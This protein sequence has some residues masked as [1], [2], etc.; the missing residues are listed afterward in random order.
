MKIERINENQFRCTLTQ[1]E[2]SARKINLSEL[3]YGSD[4]ARTLFNDL[5]EQAFTE[6]GFEAEDIPIM[7]EAIP[8]AE[9]SVMLIVTKIDDPE[10]LDTRFSRFTPASSEEEASSQAEGADDI[11]ELFRLLSEAK[12]SIQKK[13]TQK[14][15]ELTSTAL[16]RI[17]SFP[18]LD[19]ICQACAIL[20]PFFT[21]HS[22]LY[23]NSREKLYYLVVKKAGS[24]P[25]D[26]NKVCNILSEYGTRTGKS[27]ALEAYFREH[28]E[29]VIEEGAI[30]KLARI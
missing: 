14:E 29:P 3:A 18:D 20:S 28:Y 8:M 26:F 12:T 30:E 17:F 6:L 21:G 24:S 15:E 16:T 13:E 1:S 11:L 5:M 19:S 27:P 2:L 10:E 4:K 25:E 23:K 7:I 9:E 22:G